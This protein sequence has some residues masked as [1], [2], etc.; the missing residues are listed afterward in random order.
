MIVGFLQKGVFF[1]VR[2]E[3]LRRQHDACIIQDVTTRYDISKLWFGISWKSKWIFWDFEGHKPSTFM[4]FFNKKNHQAPTLG[5][6]K[7]PPRNEDALER[8]R[9]ETA[10]RTLELMEARRMVE[11]AMEGE[12]AKKCLGPMNF[13]SHVFF[14]VQIAPSGC[15]CFAGC[16]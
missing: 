4:Q 8:E 7:C 12:N 15:V 2:F 5:P 9:K 10:K 13:F 16:P 14:W 6:K 11:V 1:F 3:T